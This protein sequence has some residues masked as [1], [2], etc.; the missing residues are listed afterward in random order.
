MVR[1]LTADMLGWLQEEELALP[2]GRSSARSGGDTRRRGMCSL[3]GALQRIQRNF[4]QTSLS[5]CQNFQDLWDSVPTVWDLQRAMWRRAD[6]RG[7]NTTFD[8]CPTN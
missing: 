4:A 5:G 3:S 6:D 2:E 1:G 8:C 7:T